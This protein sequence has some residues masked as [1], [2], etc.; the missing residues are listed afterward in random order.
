MVTGCKSGCPLVSVFKESPT[1]LTQCSL[2]KNSFLFEKI[3]NEKKNM[4]LV[5]VCIII[6]VGFIGSLQGL[7]QEV[8]CLVFVLVFCIF[9]GLQQKKKKKTKNKNEKL[10]LYNCQLYL[11]IY[12]SI[13]ARRNKVGPTSFQNSTIQ[14]PLSH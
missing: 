13:Q 3:K 12:I 9:L 6:R 1:S 2:F 10:L 11:C 4:V 8:G 7:Y 5:F 14:I